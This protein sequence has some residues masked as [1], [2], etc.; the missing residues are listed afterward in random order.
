MNRNQAK[1][2]LQNVAMIEAFANGSVIQGCPRQGGNWTA[3][4]DPLFLDPP[5][6]YRIKPEP[7][8]LYA[9]SYTNTNGSASIATRS[10]EQQQNDFVDY[11][12]KYKCKDI[13]KF[14]VREV[15]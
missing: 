14:T 6:C 9:V 12:R 10:T 4:A 5:H 13:R 8:T 3:L 2:L 11:L 1:A 15:T 7:V